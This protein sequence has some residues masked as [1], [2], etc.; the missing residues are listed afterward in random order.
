LNEC[1]TTWIKDVNNGL[2]VVL[3]TSKP[4]QHWYDV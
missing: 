2:Y 3:I 4:I 1:K